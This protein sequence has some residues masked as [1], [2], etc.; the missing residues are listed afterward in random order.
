MAGEAVPVKVLETFEKL[1]RD[2]DRYLSLK[3]ING[4]MYVYEATT[5]WD[6]EHR[7][8]RSLS[9]YIGRITPDGLFIPGI[10]RD[11]ELATN[12]L[13][14]MVHRHKTKTRSMQ[15]TSRVRN[16]SIYSGK[17]EDEIIK[18]LSLNARI[19]LGELSKKLSMKPSTLN[20]RIKNIE[21][22]HRI[23]YIP[24]LN[25][26]KL[27]FH[28]HMIFI[29]FEG[30]APSVQEIRS[31]LKNYKNVQ[32]AFITHGDYDVVI[33]TLYPIGKGPWRIE[34]SNKLRE[35]LFPNYNIHLTTTAFITRYGTLRPGESFFRILEDIITDA[36]H[37]GSVPPITKR[38]FLVLRSLSEDGRRSFA[39]IDKEHG[40]GKGSSRY[41]Y[42]RL[43]AKGIIKR[44]TISME[45]TAASYLSLLFLYFQNKP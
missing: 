17:H 7:K 31:T 10:K 38:E 27:G 45:N 29:R 9:N 1:K 37:S 13:E 35:L 4:H 19:T 3:R 18:Q 43:T 25:T 36:K 14:G 16:T 40:F 12:S 20:W 34:P 26:E 28:E 6:K 2:S 30:D 39:D 21:E 11:A 32:F 8:V 42:S 41:L 44:I 5:V 15:E 22:K 33:Y 23:R 24:E